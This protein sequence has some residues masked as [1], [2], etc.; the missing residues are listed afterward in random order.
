MN[1]PVTI[2]SGGSP[3]TAL[4]SVL[5]VA[6]WLVGAAVADEAPISGSVKAVDP[7][8]QTLTIETTAKGKA[9]QVVVYLKPGAKV[10]RFTRPTEPG[11]TGFVEQPMALGDVKPGWIVSV[12]TK[13]E[14]E[15]EVADLVK[16]V[17]ER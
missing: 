5:V 16:V 12:A 14:G 10:V 9:R 4:V 2:R 3:V 17:L 13:H 6:A 1:S 8:A 15:K 11:K 7:A